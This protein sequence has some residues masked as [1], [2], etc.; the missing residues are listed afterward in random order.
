MNEMRG[1][2]DRPSIT[3]SA[4]MPCRNEVKCIEP[5]VRSILDQ[6]TPDGGFE[7]IL[8][9]GRSEDGTREILDRLAEEDERIRWVDN[10]K[11]I[12]PAGMN[13]GIQVARGRFIAILGAHNRYAHDYLAQAAR[14]LDDHPEYDNVGGS[15]FLE[16]ETDTQQAIAEVFHHPFAVGGARWHDPEYEGRA[17]TVFGGVYRR[18]VFDRIGLFDE[19]LVRNQDDEFNLRL[20]RSGGIIWHSPSIRSWYYPRKT[21]RAVFDMYRQYGYWKVRVI[22]KH[23]IPASIRHLIPGLFVFTQVFLLISILFGT[24]IAIAGLP[25]GRWLSGLSGLLFLIIMSVYGLIIGVA[26][27]RLAKRKGRQLLSRIIRAFLAFHYGYGIG[28]VEGI[29]DFVINR[30]GP[31]EKRSVLTREQNV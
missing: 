7:I 9:D 6:Q 16:C 4:V 31:S 2:P 1:Q 27:V 5:V 26:S 25:V 15:M 22:Q 18:E 10:E 20:I 19:E 21:I 23:R 12:T 28:F 17:D 14:L 24:G 8:A 11:K 13:V 3:I 30:T 29:R